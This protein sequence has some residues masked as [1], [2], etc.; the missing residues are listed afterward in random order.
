MSRLQVLRDAQARAGRRPRSL[1][2]TRAGPSMHRPAGSARGHDK[3]PER[4]MCVIASCRTPR[5]GP[6]SPP[7]N[8][9]AH[10]PP[11][12]RRSAH[13]PPHRPRPRPPIRSP[14]SLLLRT[15]MRLSLSSSANSWLYRRSCSR[16]S[17]SPSG[18][19]SPTSS[20]SGSQARSSSGTWLCAAEE[21][22]TWGGR[23]V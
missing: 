19:S 5:N 17:S 23:I 11:A 13:A 21:C 8:T 9:N 18:H 12:P 20:T 10:C 6:C 15:C 16:P 7:T 4:A 2:L 3:G 22:F 14:A 1:P